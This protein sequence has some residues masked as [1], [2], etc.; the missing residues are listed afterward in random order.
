MK[1]EKIAPA[2]IQ[3]FP[4]DQLHLSD[5]NPRQDAE[6]EGIDLLADSLAM[7]GL[8]Q[9]LSGLA[10]AETGKIGIVAGGRRLRAIARAI[11]R[12]PAV[13]ERQPTLAQIPVQITF[14][15]ETARAWA[16]AENSA[17]E[18]LDPADEIRA[19]GRMKES[20]AD[21]PTIARTFG[22]TEAQVYRRLALAA[23]PAEV[24]DALKSRQISLGMAKAFTVSQDPELTLKVLD[25]VRGKDA[26]EHRIKQLLQPDTVSGRDRR[27][28]FVG[29]DAY[30]AAG[31]TLAADLFS[32]Q[33][34]MHNPDLLSRLFAEKLE[35]EADAAC[36]GWHW[37]EI[38][39]GSY[40]PYGA[41]EKM[42][43]LYRTE[44]ILSE[45]QSER[46]DEL[47]EL[48]NGEVLDEAGQAELAALQTILDG[49]YTEDQ[50]R[51]G[52]WLVYVDD[53]GRLRKEGP[54]VKPQ[55][56][57]AATE[58]GV[59]TG[60]AAYDGSEDTGPKSPYSA[61]LVEDLKAMRLAAVQGALLDKP[62][63]ALDLA[64]YTLAQVYGGPLDLR[65]SDGKIQPST[66]TGF[67]P[68][69]RLVNPADEE[70]G[71]N[72]EGD[73]KE[74]FAAFRS[75]GQKHRN[76]ILTLALAR[77][78]KYGCT[79]FWSKSPDPLF[80]AIEGET[81]ASVRKVWTPNAE[82]FFNR[83]SGDYL[84]ALLL[85]L[86]GADPEGTGFKT[87]K[88]DKKGDK[89]RQMERLFTDPEYQ[90]AWHIDTEKKAIIDA[91]TPDCF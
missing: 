84:D 29:V 83:V 17:R 33:I 46:Y 71:D 47:A 68:D 86:T 85:E 5:L 24:L 78:L 79:D 38:M 58:A 6:P 69:P 3:Y 7:I 50:R 10:D 23:L 32:D 35:D 21:V 77:S 57:K 76:T 49:D 72:D 45:E 55:D 36:E 53:H 67:T 88:K 82:N 20:G 70:Q 39:E 90:R 31:G 62:Q 4:L 74:D 43:R 42:K 16:S 87:F 75:K 25:S 2:V 41:G 56:R 11:E 73:E 51:F 13:V 14:D 30:K 63:L 48:A 61:A 80:D 1:R 66:A 26:S 9:N 40:V 59:L 27:A 28:L 22:Q 65:A 44:G 89:A 12:D 8:V 81:K 19:Y 60:H 34:A 15:T 91:W 64:A 52:G 37:F 18:D 54:Y